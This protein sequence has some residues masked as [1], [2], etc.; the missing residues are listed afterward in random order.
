MIDH[1]MIVAHPDDELIFGYPYWKHYPQNFCIIVVTN[2]DNSIRANEF[3]NFMKYAKIGSYEIWNY[4]DSIKNTFEKSLHDYLTIVLSSRRWKC[5]ITH[6]FDGEYGH[7]QHIFLSRN[8]PSIIRKLQLKTNLGLFTFDKSRLNNSLKLNLFKQFYKSQLHILRD[9]T[10]KK[11]FNSSIDKYYDPLSFKTQYGKKCNSKP[12]CIISFCVFSNN[13]KSIDPIYLHGMLQNV[14]LANKVYPKWTV[15]FYVD[16][17]VPNKI[18]DEI[19]EHNTQVFTHLGSDTSF[20][21]KL[22]RFLPA[23]ENVRFISRDVDSRLN[24]REKQAVDQ[25]IKSDKKFHRMFDH[26]IHHNYNPLMAGMIGMQ[27]NAIPNIHDLIMLWE[28]RTP[29]SDELFLKEYVYKLFKQSGLTHG[30]YKNKQYEKLTAKASCYIG[31]KIH[32]NDS[33]FFE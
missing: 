19:L 33:R 29:S 32:P 23:C 28:D 21:R 25:W 16:K 22:W 7:P 20:R 2:G 30:R 6:N 14:L 5:V 18:I 26:P 13:S 27:K 3:K 15:R 10:I 9:G 24:K 4:K 1:L 31:E 17:Y 8:I 12:T 11:L